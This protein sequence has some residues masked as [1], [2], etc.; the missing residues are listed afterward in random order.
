MRFLTVTNLRALSARALARELDNFRAGNGSNAFS[1]FFSSIPTDISLS[2]RTRL[3]KCHASLLSLKSSPEPHVLLALNESLR[4]LAGIRATVAYNKFL[5]SKVTGYFSNLPGPRKRLCIAGAPI[6][7]MCNVVA[8]MMFGVGVS[9]LSYAG[10]V[11]VAI[12]TNDH[13]VD[14]PED[15]ISEIEAAFEGMCELAEHPEEDI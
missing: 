15:L 9:V 11:V 4:S 6:A 14:A 12:S 5:L 1:Y 8:P 13:A 10:N 7:Q 2:K 3:S